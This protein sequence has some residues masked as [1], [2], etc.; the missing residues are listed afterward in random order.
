MPL[1]ARLACVFALV[2]VLL[3][4][5]ADFEWHDLSISNS[6]LATQ[7]LY[8]FLVNRKLRIYP[9]QDLREHVLN[10]ATKET[11]RVFRLTKEKQTKK[12]DGCVALSFAC[13]G[14]NAIRPPANVSN[15]PFGDQKQHDIRCA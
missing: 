13:A 15:A 3:S 6:A 14:C 5:L 4:G 1:S 11:E 9:S 2:D 12:I 7:T 10:V 8:D